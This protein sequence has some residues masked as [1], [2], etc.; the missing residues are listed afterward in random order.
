VKNRDAVLVTVL[1]QLRLLLLL[2]GQ[3]AIV[4]DL[5]GRLEPDSTTAVPL[6]A[7]AGPDLHTV[8][9]EASVLDGKR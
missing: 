3:K 1:G 7:C 4:V 6:P 8:R 9:R 5:H 2:V